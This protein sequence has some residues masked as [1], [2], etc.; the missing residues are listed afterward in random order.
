MVPTEDSQQTAL[1]L[2]PEIAGKEKKE[3]S[4]KNAQLRAWDRNALPSKLAIAPNRRFLSVFT[5]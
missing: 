2:A 1:F 4:T 5:P 3:T